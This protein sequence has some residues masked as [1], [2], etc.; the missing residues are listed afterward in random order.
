[1]KALLKSIIPFIGTVL[2]TSTA[3]S[4]VSSI[5]GDNLVQ[6]GKEEAYW[7]ADVTCDDNSQR[8]IQRKTDGDQWC[9]IDFDGFC[10]T[11]KESTAKKV[12]SAQ[13]TSSLNLLEATKQAQN[14]AAEAEERAKR[15]EEA[16]AQSIRAEQRRLADQR[17]ESQR[18]E[19]QRV[20]NAAEVEPLKKRINIDEDIIRIENEKLKLRRQELEL[21][22]RAS[23]IQSLLGEDSFF[24]CIIR[25]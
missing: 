17:L 8:G 20:A 23:E 14:S 25:N 2:F 15:A 11:T 16:R 24:L 18:L 22:R 19:R 12:C 7:V 3:V 6:Y 5:S 9:G 13:Y 4:E 21:Q 1:M 10:D